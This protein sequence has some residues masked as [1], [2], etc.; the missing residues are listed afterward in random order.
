MRATGDKFFTKR[1]EPRPPRDERAGRRHRPLTRRTF[2]ACV[3][4]GVLTPLNDDHADAGKTVTFTLLVKDAGTQ[5]N[6]PVQY[7]ELQFL[8]DPSK[9]VVVG[10]A[11]SPFIDYLRSAKDGRYVVKFVATL[12]TRS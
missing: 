11:G 1:A 7:L 8:D 6:D 5:L 4:T 9:I 3:G 2:L 12:S 10:P